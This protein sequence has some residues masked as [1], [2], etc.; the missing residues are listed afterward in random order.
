MQTINIPVPDSLD[1]EELKARLIGQ[2]NDESEAARRASQK[3]KETDLILESDDYMH[4]WVSNKYGPF[5]RY[6]QLAIT[7]ASTYSNIHHLQELDVWRFNRN[8]RRPV[9][10]RGSREFLR[11]AYSLSSSMSDNGYCISV[12][13]RYLES[14]KLTCF[15]RGEYLKILESVADRFMNKEY[16]LSYHYHR[17]SRNYYDA[18]GIHKFEPDSATAW[19]GG[20]RVF[21]TVNQFKTLNKM[22]QII[23]KTENADERLAMLKE[24]HINQ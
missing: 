13:D 17:S 19:I 7:R 23:R 4:E 10:M 12:L 2:L 8:P 20:K 22:H 14:L 1:A 11:L 16:N 6:Q 21:L 24:Y 18:P 9:L 5:R 15:D 3:K